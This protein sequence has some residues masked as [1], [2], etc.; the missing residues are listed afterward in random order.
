MD[1]SCEQ[2]GGKMLPRFR[3]SSGSGDIPPPPTVRVGTKCYKPLFEPSLARRSRR[4]C[5]CTEVPEYSAR[6]HIISGYRP[7][8]KKP[9]GLVKTVM[10]SLTFFHNESGNILTH[11]VGVIAVPILA[12]YHFFGAGLQLTLLDKIVSGVYFASVF[13]CFAASVCFHALSS[14]PYPT[15]QRALSCDM[16][17]IVACILGSFYSGLWVGFRCH[18]PHAHAYMGGITLLAAPLIAIVAV[19]RLRRNC[20]LSYPVFAFVIFSGLVPT[21]Q[22]ALMMRADAEDRSMSNYVIVWS[23]LAMFACY[24]LGMLV[25]TTRFPECF[26][27]GKFDYVFASHQFWHLMVML[28]FLV[29]YLGQLFVW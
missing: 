27:P 19:P 23:L 9:T 22:F 3:R 29:Q 16:L 7:L 25:F 20:L 24:A 8:P 1:G 14:Q 13:Y 5:F 28:A 2:Q 11:L 17:G 6:P 26:F 12:I 10:H 21:Y 15:Y 18:P 4:L